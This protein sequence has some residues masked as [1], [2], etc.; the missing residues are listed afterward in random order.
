MILSGWKQIANY[1]QCS[2]RTAQRWEEYGLPVRRPIRG[3]RGQ[4]VAQS[5]DIESW[6]RSNQLQRA[7]DLDVIATIVK[8][9]KL[10]DEVQQ[11]RDMLLLRVEALRKQIAILRARRLRQ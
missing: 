10:C 9:K 4:V 1:M 7:V 3:G 5:A 6:L 11:S 8:A 2:V